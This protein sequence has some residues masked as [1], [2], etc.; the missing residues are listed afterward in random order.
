MTSVTLTQLLTLDKDEFENILEIYPQMKKA[1][2]RHVKLLQR[3]YQK[4]DTLYAIQY[5]ANGGKGGA[6]GATKRGSGGGKQQGGGGGGGEVLGEV[7]GE[8]QHV[9]LELAKQQQV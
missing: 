1:L 4:M 6:G 9:R 2:L 8:L 5:D 3:K 7:L